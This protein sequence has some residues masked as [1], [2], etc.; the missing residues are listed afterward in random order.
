MSTTALARPNAP[1]FMADMAALVCGSS[2]SS[3][4]PPSFTPFMSAKLSLAAAHLA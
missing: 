3:R 2:P 1:F 4:T